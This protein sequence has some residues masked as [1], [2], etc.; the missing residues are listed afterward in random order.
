MALLT[1][2]PLSTLRSGLSAV[3]AVRIPEGG[4]APADIGESRAFARIDIRDEH[5]SIT[6]RY[7]T[8]DQQ[9]PA[10][11]GPRPPGM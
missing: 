7:L 9:Q 11:D 1:E 10:Q 5:D 2:V 3:G 6:S 8:P 4:F